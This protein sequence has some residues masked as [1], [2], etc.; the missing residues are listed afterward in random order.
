MAMDKAAE[1]EKS[2]DRMIHKRKT[3]VT[4]HAFFP[5]LPATHAEI[6][7]QNAFSTPLF[8]VPILLSAPRSPGGETGL[9]RRKRSRAVK[10]P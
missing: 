2:R 10:A 4:N 8:P 1:R 5:L 3:Q 7:P 6:L 9:R